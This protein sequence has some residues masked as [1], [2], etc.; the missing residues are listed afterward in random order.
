MRSSY[1]LISIR[2]Y[3]III[4]YVLC[5]AVLCAAAAVAAAVSF[6]EEVYGSPDLWIVL[7]HGGTGDIKSSE[8][9]INFLRLA[10]D[11]EGYVRALALLHP[12]LQQCGV[13]CCCCR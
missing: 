3:F 9:K 11:M 2:L 5:C 6:E 4:V 1:F 10:S 13:S 7:Y 8:H 12:R